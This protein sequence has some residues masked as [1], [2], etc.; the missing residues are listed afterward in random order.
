MSESISLRI[1]HESGIIGFFKG[2][3][4]VSTCHIEQVGLGDDTL[5]EY[6]IKAGGIRNAI[7]QIPLLSNYV[8][9]Y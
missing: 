7:A 1:N 4:E 8:N 3:V 2:E 6:V 9:T 5:E